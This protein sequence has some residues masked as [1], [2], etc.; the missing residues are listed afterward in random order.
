MW[1]GEEEDEMSNKTGQ[2][3]W[4]HSEATRWIIMMTCLKIRQKKCKQ[5][6]FQ[7]GTH[8]RNNQKKIHLWSDCSFVANQVFK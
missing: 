6:L 7:M 3:N 4:T 1:N 8:S 2:K 5:R